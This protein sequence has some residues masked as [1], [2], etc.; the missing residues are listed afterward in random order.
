MRA[1][2]VE[3]QVEFQKQTIPTKPQSNSEA[4]IVTTMVLALPYSNIICTSRAT[5]LWTSSLIFTGSTVSWISCIRFTHYPSKLSPSSGKIE[6]LSSTSAN[7]LHG[8]AHLTLRGSSRSKCSLA[9]C[10]TLR[11]FHQSQKA[12]FLSWPWMLHPVFLACNWNDEKAI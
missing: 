12:A 5:R 7:I 3:N 9:I 2:P 10:K 4:Y 11:I 6:N 8:R 1:V